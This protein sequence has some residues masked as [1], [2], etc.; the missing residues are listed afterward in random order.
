MKIT[1]HTFIKAISEVMS[2][3]PV[4]E[5]F[6]SDKDAFDQFSGFS[7]LLFIKID[8]KDVTKSVYFDAVAQLVTELLPD[9][10]SIA[11]FVRILSLIMFTSQIW[12]RLGKN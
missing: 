11:S 6:D 3:E 9:N 10:P 7:Y 5:L 12:D 1:K 4:L 2:T 8:G